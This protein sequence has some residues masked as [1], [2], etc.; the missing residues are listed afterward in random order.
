MF[1]MRH[2]EYVFSR[3]TPTIRMKCLTWE[4]VFVE[5]IG[6]NRE[7]SLLIHVYA[8][9]KFSRQ[10]MKIQHQLLR[11]SPFLICVPIDEFPSSPYTPPKVHR[12]AGYG[13]FLSEMHRVSLLKLEGKILHMALQRLFSWI[14]RS[15][16]TPDFAVLYIS[17]ALSLDYQVERSNRY[18]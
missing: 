13:G 16:A 5:H 14:L 12:S 4:E 3:A 7:Y 8:H 11:V 9:K 17:F 6:Q 10:I 2:V 18:T 1:N 15:H